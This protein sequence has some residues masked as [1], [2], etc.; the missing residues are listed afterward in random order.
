MLEGAKSIGAGAAVGIGNVFSSLIHSVARNPSMGLA[1][2][3]LWIR[4]F[5]WSLQVFI[6][7]GYT[8]LFFDELSRAV[9][10]FLDT[11]G[12][13]LSNPGAV[14]PV[15][16]S[17]SGTMIPI[18]NA[19]ES[20]PSS[21]SPTASELVSRWEPVP[22]SPT[23]EIPLILDVENPISYEKR[24]EALRRLMNNKVQNGLYRAPLKGKP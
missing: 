10:P 13:G 17:S 14:P 8:A 21:P 1:F 3:F 22:D 16:P 9:S 23:V 7:P 20:Y 24:E 4:S 2:L 18:T 6:D 11:T 19:H 5:F 12:S 15:G